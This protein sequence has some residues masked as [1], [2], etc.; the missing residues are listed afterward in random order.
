MNAL[1]RWPIVLHL[2]WISAASLVNANNWLAKRGTPVGAKTAA[3]AASAAAAWPSSASA[4][5]HETVGA[6]RGSARGGGRRLI[7]VV[8]PRAE[9]GYLCPER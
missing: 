8:A 2:G 7:E 1:V 5:A 6:W 3:S 9:R 4:G